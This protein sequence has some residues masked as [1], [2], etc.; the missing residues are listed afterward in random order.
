MNQIID[1][2]IRVGFAK[3]AL[4]YWFSI[5]TCLYS[6][7]LVIPFLVFSAFFKPN[8][9]FTMGILLTAMLELMDYVTYLITNFNGME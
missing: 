2:H 9:L 5:W 8:F 6:I 1:L 3:I 7:A 4:K